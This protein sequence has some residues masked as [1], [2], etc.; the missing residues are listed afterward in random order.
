ME[1]LD[2][3]P[4]HRHP[5]PHRELA[6]RYREQFRNEDY[7]LA[8][9]LSVLALIASMG[10][11]LL[12]GHFSN[13]HASNP[14]A[15]LILSNTPALHVDAFFVYGTFLF[16]IFVAAI[17][18]AHPRRIPFTFMSLAVFF[19]VRAGF[20]TLTHIAPFPEQSA[21]NFGGTIR[22][23]FFGSDLFFS[24]HTG[25]PFLM[26]LIFWESKQL[27]Y[28]FLVWSIFFAAVVLL[29]HLHYSI[30]VASAFFITY[31]VFHLCET[32]FPGY[33]ALFYSDLSDEEAQGA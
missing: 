20:V 30:D 29:G 21:T 6:R 1:A 16:G 9:A 14:V 31:S 7:R 26:A 10:A 12:A 33:R 24:G 25:T 28:T 8:V 5:R 11:S 32:L 13:T 15:D 22:H 27:R 23:Y 17:A 3:V 2:T 18:F 19:F 4:L